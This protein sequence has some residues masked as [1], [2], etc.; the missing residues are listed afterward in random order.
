MLHILMI[1]VRQIIHAFASTIIV[2]YQKQSPLGVL[3]C[4][5]YFWN[6]D[7]QQDTF[8]KS[9]KFGY[10]RFPSF[11]FLEEKPLDFTCAS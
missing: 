3:F 6:T 8:Q 2:K 5:D 4:S 11:C 1:P 10:F 7:V 9:R